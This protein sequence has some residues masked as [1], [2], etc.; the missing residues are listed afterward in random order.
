MANFGYIHYLNWA[1]EK[2]E[3]VN[4]L[5]STWDETIREGIKNRK[6]QWMKKRKDYDDGTIEYFRKEKPEEMDWINEQLLPFDPYFLTEERPLDDIIHAEGAWLFH[7]IASDARDSAENYAYIGDKEN[8][9]KWFKKAVEFYMKGRA[10][11]EGLVKEKKDFLVVSEWASTGMDEYLIN[12]ILSEDEKLINNVAK[13]VEKQIQEVDHVLS[14]LKHDY[15]I[16]FC[17][18]ILAQIILDKKINLPKPLEKKI[19]KSKKEYNRAGKL[20]D[21]LDHIYNKNLDEIRV[22]LNRHLGFWKRTCAQSCGMIQ[23]SWDATA[24]NIIAK[25]LGIYLLSYVDDVNLNVIP[26]V[27]GGKGIVDKKEDDKIIAELNSKPTLEIEPLKKS[28]DNEYIWFTGLIF[29]EKDS[30]WDTEEI[31]GLCCE[32][33]ELYKYSKYF[34]CRFKEKEGVYTSQIK[35]KKDGYYAFGSIPYGRTYKDLEDRGYAIEENLDYYNFT[36]FLV[37]AH[38]K[39]KKLLWFKREDIV[40]SERSDSRDVVMKKWKEVLSSQE[41]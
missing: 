4:N 37:F 11:N 26:E 39:N 16:G 13:E 38:F 36:N 6:E 33:A 29:Q 14:T 3:N 23:I 18:Y 20:A 40:I 41:K 25:K 19:D 32:P 35:I 9:K 34:T 31:I 10:I 15:N 5:L 2:E 21:T 12:A 30:K 8:A 28:T 24:F 22:P 17:G 7:H 1:K 27:Y